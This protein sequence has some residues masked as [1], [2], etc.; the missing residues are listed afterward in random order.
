MAPPA[1][2]AFPYRAAD[3]ASHAPPLLPMISSIEVSDVYLAVTCYG[4]RVPVLAR[5]RTP[6]PLVCLID[7][8]HGP[9]TVVP[10]IHQRNVGKCSA[11]ILMANAGSGLL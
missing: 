1:Q 5:V 4:E 9:R 10:A 2:I 8:P 6:R 3:N 7:Q 11:G